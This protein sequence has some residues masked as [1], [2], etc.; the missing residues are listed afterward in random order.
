MAHVYRGVK[1]AFL[2]PQEEKCGDDLHAANRLLGQGV[3]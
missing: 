2:Y 1:A 3:C